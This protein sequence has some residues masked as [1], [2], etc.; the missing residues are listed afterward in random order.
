MAAELLT[1][2]GVVVEADAE[3]PAEVA[4]VEV[5]LSEP[6]QTPP[7]PQP[8]PPPPQRPQQQKATAQKASAPKRQRLTG[9]AKIRS[10]ISALE[11]KIAQKK[12]KWAALQN[13]VGATPSTQTC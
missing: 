4:R 2:A 9:A 3:A 12:G 6:P 5:D 7:P 8:P 13:K 1:F 11:I 10:D